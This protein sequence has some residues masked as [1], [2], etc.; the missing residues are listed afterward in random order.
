MLNGLIPSDEYRIDKKGRRIRQSTPYMRVD[1]KKW[2]QKNYGD[3]PYRSSVDNDAESRLH[4][5]EVDF[6]MGRTATARAKALA[7]IEDV[8]EGRAAINR[9]NLEMLQNVLG[10]NGELSGGALLKPRVTNKW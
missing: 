6:N 1:I 2:L 4:G 9:D 10:V 8:R 5:I 7:L 3:Y